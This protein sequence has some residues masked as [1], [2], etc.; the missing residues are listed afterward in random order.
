MRK[1]DHSFKTEILERLK[2]E[3]KK[4]YDLAKS[5]YDAAMEHSRSDDMKSE[6]KYDTRA[7]E[8][9]YLASAKKARMTDLK[10]Q[11]DSLEKLEFS[12]KKTVSVGSLMAL[13]QDTKTRTIFV[14]PGTSVKIQIEDLMI[15][16]LSVD[17][18]VIKEALGLEAGEVFSLETPQGEVDFEIIELI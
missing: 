5:S 9:G 14:T 17:S 3:A 10:F 12:P 7:I 4:S 8:A 6:G 18:P 13:E 2:L 11:W 15:E 1:L 16:A